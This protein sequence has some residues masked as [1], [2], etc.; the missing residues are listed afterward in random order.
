MQHNRKQVTGLPPIYCAR[1]QPSPPYSSLWK[2][3]TRPT[4]DLDCIVVEFLAK[5]VPLLLHSTWFIRPRLIVILVAPV[6]PITSKN[7]VKLWRV[8]AQLSNRVGKP[9]PESRLDQS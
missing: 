2:N 4:P 8:T 5:F 6:P 9:H 7:E 3:L 1:I